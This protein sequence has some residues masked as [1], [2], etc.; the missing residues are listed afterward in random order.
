MERAL[1]V[2]RHRVPCGEPCLRR[3]AGDAEPLERR[4]QVG[5]QFRRCLAAGGDVGVG[6][7]E[8]VRQFVQERREVG[9]LV[10][11]YGQSLRVE[12]A[13]WSWSGSR[14]LEDPR[15]GDVE[16]ARQRDDVA[17]LVVGDGVGRLY[18]LRLKHNHLIASN[19]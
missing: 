19:D 18:L 5:E 3:V 2:E 10:E 6:R 12:P 14:L 11:Q 17:G 13:A 7:E 9:L 8:V 1:L 4:V 16:A 15:A